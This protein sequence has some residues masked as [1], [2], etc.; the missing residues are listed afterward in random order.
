MI[1]LKLFQRLEGG[2]DFTY[3]SGC[4][5]FLCECFCNGTYVCPPERSTNFCDDKLDMADRKGRPSMMLNFLSG[6]DTTWH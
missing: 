1:Y 5:E 4:T 3:R 6:H 2:R